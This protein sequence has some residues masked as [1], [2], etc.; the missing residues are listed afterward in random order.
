LLT[1]L[2]EITQTLQHKI[3]R[4]N[5]KYTVDGP[6]DIVLDGFPGPLGQVITNLFNNAILHGFEGG[7]DGEI[8]IR[9]NLLGDEVRLL[10]SDNGLGVTA[11]N[12]SKLFDPFYTTKLGEGGSGLGLNIVHNIITSWMG[13]EISVE[14]RI[15]L[16][17]EIK[18]PLIAPSPSPRKSQH[19]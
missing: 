6:E 15:G 1:T 2:N 8:K 5:I 11:E 3:K 10:F 13:G 17:F 9:F 12:L 7:N 19:E 4:T 18:L 14:S 16:T